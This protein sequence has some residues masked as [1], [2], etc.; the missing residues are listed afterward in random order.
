MKEKVNNTIIEDSSKAP[1]VWAVMRWFVENSK[2][3]EEEKLSPEYQ[4][5]IDNLDKKGMALIDGEEPSKSENKDLKRGLKV[6]KQPFRK[7]NIDN[8]KVQENRDV[9][10][11]KEILE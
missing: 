6:E 8:T 4:N 2:K 9:S 11:E 3:E 5:V 7:G 1:G 10:K